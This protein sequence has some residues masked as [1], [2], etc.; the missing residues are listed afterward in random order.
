MD[1]YLL[2]PF[3]FL[4]FQ[5]T[6][7]IWGQ[8][9]VRMTH[10][11]RSLCRHCRRV[12]PTCQKRD[13]ARETNA[14]PQLLVR[15]CSLHIVQL[16]L[17]HGL[18]HL[19]CHDPGL[20]V[21]RAQEVTGR[22]SRLRRRSRALVPAGHTA[23]RRCSVGGVRGRHRKEVLATAVVADGSLAGNVAHRL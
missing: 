3:T 12:V 22:G 23:P 20:I 1:D 8:S 9:R 13:L 2:A 11:K 19:I 7:N 17:H 16:L 15:Q 5:G 6:V 18:R 4:P 14:L 21:C 10:R